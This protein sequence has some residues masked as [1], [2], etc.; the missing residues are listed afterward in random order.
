MEGLEARR[1]GGLKEARRLLAP[2]LQA[3]KPSSLPSSLQASKP[4][5]LL[6][7]FFVMRAPRWRDA[8]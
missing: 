3:F 4:P 7:A 2:S 5:S 1:L 6:Q 8:P